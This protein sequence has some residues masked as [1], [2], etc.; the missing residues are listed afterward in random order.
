[1]NQQEHQSMIQRDK[2]IGLDGSGSSSIVANTPFECLMFD[3][4]LFVIE[5]P[6]IYTTSKPLFVNEPISVLPTIFEGP[7]VD[8]SI[9]RGKTP[10]C[11]TFF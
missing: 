9:I 7:I 10:R 5:A 8:T 2:K 11:P 4:P 3:V 1:M 6:P